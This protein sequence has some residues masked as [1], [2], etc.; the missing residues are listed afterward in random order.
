MVEEQYD[1]ERGSTKM[2]SREPVL[3]GR[4]MGGGGGGGGGA[5]IQTNMRAL[6]DRGRHLGF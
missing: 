2:L 5:T 6:S 3:L 4:E 1:G